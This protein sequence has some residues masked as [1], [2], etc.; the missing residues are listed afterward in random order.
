LNNPSAVT[1][2]I[3]SSVPTQVSSTINGIAANISSQ[4]NG[5][6]SQYIDQLAAQ[7]GLRQWY[8][9]HVMD[10]CEGW[11]SPSAT[12]LGASYNTTKCT[13][14]T[15][16]RKLSPGAI[17]PI[18]HNLTDNDTD[19]FD[20]ATLINND[21]QLGALHKNLTDIQWPSQLTDAI[22]ALNILLDV[23]FI[24]YC[25]GVGCC[26]IVI[27]CALIAFFLPSRYNGAVVEHAYHSAFV[28]FIGGA[29]TLLAFLTLGA[30]S[31][32]MTVFIV[33][34]KD[35]INQRANKIGIYA[36]SG[37]KFLAI[38]WAATGVMLLATI[39]WCIEGCFRRR[40]RNRTYVDKTVQPVPARGWRGHV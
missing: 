36:Y 4:L 39:A 7:V 32:V 29:F 25:V 2:N 34:A 21:L 6:E 15:A 26:G 13:N 38:T 28:N 19:H 12:A 14:K 22:N 11:Y 37:D 9:L 24:L 27:I 3:P 10:I 17:L 1:D 5:A 30:A 16:M 40:I 31:A 18:Q 35:A 23:T 33:K 20:I 8:S